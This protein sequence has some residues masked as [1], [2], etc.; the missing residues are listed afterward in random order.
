MF[1]R[2]TRVPVARTC[3]GVSARTAAWVPTTMNAGVGTA[4]WGVVM[5][6]ARAAPSR[7][8]G[9]KP[10]AGDEG[11]TD[12]QGSRSASLAGG[13]RVIPEPFADRLMRRVRELG[14]PL[15]AGFDPA[16]GRIPPPFRR[17]SMTAADPASADAVLGFGR[18]YLERVAGRVAV[19]K[20]QSAFFE[21]MGPAGSRALQGFVAEARALGLLVLL[22]A[23]RGDVGST[24]EG[25]AAAYLAEGAPLQADALTVSPYLGVDTLEPFVRCAA[26]AG[27]G[28]FVLTRTSNPGGRDFQELRVSGA[29]LY[30]HVARA[31]APLAK[32]LLGAASGW[33]GLGLVVGAPYPEESVRLRE[34]AP[35]SL[36]LVPGYGA[37]GASADEAVAGFV[38]GA[39]GRREGGV[40]NSSRALHFPQAADDAASWERGVD[41]AL[42]RA[43]D[44]L[45][46]AC[47]R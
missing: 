31:L 18:A 11:A 8:S 20:P 17:G 13:G 6:A 43:C 42:A 15:C 44:E 3:S 37:Q 7:P 14:H 4:P 5:V 12:R 9:A 27:G 39:A 10:S 22:D 30:E 23:K 34:A 38:R 46:E 25:Y 33:S 24:A 1:A 41:A 29:T 35:T 32:T 26:G 28:V 19:V 2:T 47:A 21:V 40:V 16:L 45:A 36:F